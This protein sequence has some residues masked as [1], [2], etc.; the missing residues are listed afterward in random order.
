[1]EQGE[2]KIRVLI[3]KVG[4]DNHDI[5]IKVLATAFKEA[6]MEVIFLGKFLTAEKVVRAAIEE[7][8][9]V[10]AL[11]D[12]CG[13]M[14]VIASDVVGLL[15]KNNADSICVVAGGLIP[16]EDIPYLEE[17]GVTGNFGSGTPLDKIINHVVERTRAR[18]GRSP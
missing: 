10:I 11:S 13:A 18:E 8:V 7:D 3:G 4:L 12:H 9:D 6:A 16:K 2:R 5:G 17:L 15:K 1:M 14:R